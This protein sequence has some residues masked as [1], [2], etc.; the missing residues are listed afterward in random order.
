MKIFYKT[1]YYVVEAVQNIITATMMATLTIGLPVVLMYWFTNV[2]IL[3]AFLITIAGW[4]GFFLLSTIAHV[5]S[6]AH[7]KGENLIKEESETES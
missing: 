3:T 4:L 1:V 2:N 6:K 5:I 7:D